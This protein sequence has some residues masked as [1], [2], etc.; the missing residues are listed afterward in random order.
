MNIADYIIVHE[1]CHLKEM[2]RSKKFW[3]LVG[4][5]FPEHKAIRKKL[6]RLIIVLN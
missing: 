3:D 1:L 2:D 4:L 5:F 6:K